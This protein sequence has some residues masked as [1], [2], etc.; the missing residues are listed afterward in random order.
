MNNQKSL[1]T[2]TFAVIVIFVFLFLV[3]TFDISYPLALTTT[4]RTSELSVVGEGKKEAIPDTAYVD[5]GITVN[6]SQTVESTQK[7]INETNNKIVEAMKKLN[8]K[9]EDIKTSNYSI[10]PNYVYEA[11]QNRITGYNGNVSLSIKIK[12]LKQTAKVVE[13]ATKAGA[14]NIQGTRFVVDD[15]DKYREL[16]REEAIANGKEQAQKL[17]KTLGIK[18]GKIVNIVESTPRYTQSESFTKALSSSAGGLGGASDNAQ[19][20]PGSQTISS[21]VTLYFE[22]K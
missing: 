7:T 5:V 4:T 22:K 9:S 19:F 18:L 2:F 1:I 15:P 6:N 21:V 11:S 13:E 10:Y 14:N 16:A 17:A 20:E 3:K 8:I 12:D